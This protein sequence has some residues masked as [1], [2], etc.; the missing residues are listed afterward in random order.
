MVDEEARDGDGAVFEPLEQ[1][2]DVF[3][4]GCSGGV[5]A[6]ERA[7][8]RAGRDAGGED[9]GEGLVGVGVHLDVDV[10]CRCG[11]SMSDILGCEEKQFET[12]YPW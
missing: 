12:Y 1:R 2:E 7:A 3:F 11:M 5:G 8:G 4:E 9:A 10:G 6:G